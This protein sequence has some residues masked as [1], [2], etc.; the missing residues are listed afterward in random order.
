MFSFNSWQSGTAALMALA[1]TAG[2]TAP[3]LTS[4]P[5]LAQ[6]DRYPDR[7]DQYPDRSD[8]YPDRS[9]RY[10]DHSD[11]YPDH[12]DRRLDRSDQYQ[13]SIPAGT[14]IPVRYEKAEKIVVTP[15]ETTSLTLTVAA[16]ITNRN[17][18]VLIPAGTK[19][20]GQLEPVERRSEK[21]SRFVARELVLN[22]DQ[23]RDID[24]TSRVITRT[25]RI[26]KGASS[27]SILE[28]AAAGGAAAALISGVTGNHHIPVG[29]VLGGAGAGAVGGLL[30]GRRNAD[31]V[32]IYP[33][34][35]L[36]LRLG[37]DLPVSY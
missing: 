16:D 9:D 31:V 24:A 13:V 15:D 17:G 29:A 34:R 20:V 37:S 25:E 1:I 26:T 21:G 10:P 36:D 19:I 28:G 22:S 33:D 14:R 35:D 4:A 11:R 27:G 23:R 12:S 6:S 7:S 8:Q 5:A 18:N 32:V 3:I 30:L 2:A